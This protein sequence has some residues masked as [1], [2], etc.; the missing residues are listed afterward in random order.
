MENATQTRKVRSSIPK[1]VLP[2]IGILC[3]LCV[4]AAVVFFRPLI[5]PDTVQI[6]TVTLSDMEQPSAADFVAGLENTDIWVSFEKEYDAE[7]LGWQEVSLRF[8]RGYRSC[9]V[10]AQL[11]RFHIEPE[12]T[13]Q[14][15]QESAVTIRDF[16]PDTTISAELVTSLTEG[17]CGL[18]LVQLRCEERLYT[19]QCTV[20]EDIPPKGVGK[21]VV[22]EAGKI[23]DPSIF[24]EQIEDHTAVT[25]TYKE[26]QQF[27]LAGRHKLTLVLTD[28]FGNTTEIEAA[29]NVIPAVNGPQFTGMTTLYLELGAAVAYKADVTATDAQD[30]ILTFTVDP[31]GLD[32]KTPGTYT[33]FYSAEDSDGNV[34]IMPRTV[35]VESHIGQIVRQKAQETLDLIITPGMTQDEKIYAVFRR[36]KD[37]MG[38]AFTGDKSSLENAAYEGFTKWY[39]DCYTYY[40]MVRVMLDMLEIPN[41]EVVRVGG[42]SNHWWNLVQFEDGKYYHVDAIPHQTVYFRHFK[43]T[44]SM[45]ESYTNDP[46]VAQRRPN[47]YVYDHTLP[48]YQGIEIAQ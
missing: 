45:I 42:T 1:W 9:V 41:V 20:T 24:V 17:A 5:L 15:G 18:F 29:V 7:K 11:Y 19:V 16:V 40:A 33:V 38:Y 43:M 31:N 21:E 10:T 27:I 47:Y 26:P 3:A 12:L 36:V 8:H 30:G 28:L 48:Q 23:P 39:G 4:C 6:Q 37:Y 46:E 22:A 25:V 13:V 2:L 14:L 34:L 32:T 44:E 35:V